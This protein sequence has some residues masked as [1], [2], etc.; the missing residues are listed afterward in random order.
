MTELIAVYLMYGTSWFWA[1]IGVVFLLVMT[2]SETEHEYWAGAIFVAFVSLMEMAGNI[3]IFA[4]PLMLLKWAVIYIAVGVAWSYIKWMFF[5]FRKK[6]HLVVIKEKFYK[7]GK[8]HEKDQLDRLSQNT[9]MAARHAGMGRQP[10]P[11]EIPPFTMA[12]PTSAIPAVNFGSF[13]R[14]AHD[15]GFINDS[16]YRS[17]SPTTMKDIFPIWR[18]YKEQIGRWIAFWPTSLIWTMLDHPIRRLVNVI[19]ES[20]RGGYQIMT[21]AVFKDVA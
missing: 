12:S 1:S 15:N 17:T 6:E 19:I 10:E 8:D 13:V 11:T 18:F 14:F 9:Q 5:M 3:S 4:D 20:F 2:L 16:Q 21:N 7:M